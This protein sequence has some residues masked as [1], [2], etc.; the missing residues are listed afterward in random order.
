MELFKFLKDE[1]TLIW[2]DFE[3]K[4]PKDIL[5]I[6]SS[7]LKQLI[8][9]KVIQ[10]FLSENFQINKEILD[11]FE[12]IKNYNDGLIKCILNIYFNS[13]QNGFEYQG[14]NLNKLITEWKESNFSQMLTVPL[15]AL[16]YLEGY[17]EILSNEIYYKFNFLIAL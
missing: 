7:D 3:L 8:Q 9:R 6:S 15:L 17:K 10:N 12:E 2:D 13:G 11:M 1:N 16:L 14:K 4:E 5:K